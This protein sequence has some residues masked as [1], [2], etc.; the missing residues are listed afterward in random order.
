M[1]SVRRGLMAGVIF[2]VVFAALAQEAWAIPA[3][4]RKYKTGCAT[5][6]EAFPRLNAVGEAFRLNGYRFADDELYLK[7]EPV[8]LGDEA[9]KRLWPDAV[10]PVDIPGLPPVSIR[11]LSDL[12][13][14][15][16]GTE[17]ARTE[18]E[19]PHEVEILTGGTLGDNIHFFGHIAFEEEETET[20][21]TLGFDDLFGPENALNLKVGSLH[22]GAMGL[23]TARNGN[24]LTK[25]SYLYAEWTMPYPGGF[26]EENEYNIGDG[27]PGLEANGFGSRWYYGLG[28]VEGSST[29]S[30]KDVYLQ[31]AFKAGGIGFDGSGAVDKE[32]ALPSSGAESWRDDSLTFSIF[33]Y[34]G[35]AGIDFTDQTEDRFWRIGPGLQ[36]KRKDLTL[37]TGYIFGRNDEPY[38]TL[39]SESVDSESWFVEASYFVKPW[40]IPSI[41]YETLTLDLPSG[42]AG[43]QEDQDR[44]RI[45]AS[46]KALIRPNVSLTVEG[47]FYTED[48]RSTE[49]IP[50]GDTDDDSQLVVRMDFAF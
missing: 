19:A 13:V 5:C 11:V 28:I 26:S 20:M 27:Q 46:T 43:L 50:G 22:G 8:E 9:Y 6:H 16:G 36:W 44:A 33:A 41:R 4:S 12:N 23:F 40:L 37:G 31:V 30:D 18:F 1:R 49:A 17:Q 35:T 25:N 34:R 42:V 3:F 21:A 48:E 45:V 38:G 32:G 15:I 39:T 10:W 24:R 29:V 7:D 47:R 2:T 14:D